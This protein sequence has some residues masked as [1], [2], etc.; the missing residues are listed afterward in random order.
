LNFA[1]FFK[2]FYCD[3]FLV[4]Q[5]SSPSG[6]SRDCSSC[7]EEA[8]GEI[9]AEFNDITFFI[10]ACYKSQLDLSYLC[11]QSQNVAFQHAPVVPQ[12]AHLSMESAFSGA[13]LQST[14]YHTEPSVRQVD[15][16]TGE[17]M[18]AFAIKVSGDTSKN[19]KVR[20]AN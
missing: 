16:K 7:S 8:L 20:N 6:S 15:G 4:F 19:S 17:P 11:F 5:R 2:W 18:F 9:A 13:E 12:G 3:C 10:A 1:D 14:L